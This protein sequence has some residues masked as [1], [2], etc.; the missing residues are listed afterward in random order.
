MHI[1]MRKQSGRLKLRHELQSNWR[2]FFKNAKGM[3]RKVQEL[4]QNKGDPN[5]MHDSDLDPELEVKIL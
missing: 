1:V 2:A 3:E 4:F 5:A